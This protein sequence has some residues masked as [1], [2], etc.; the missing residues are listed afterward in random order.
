MDE[1]KN[2]NTES[3]FEKRTGLIVWLKTKRN[4]RRLMNFGL[5]HYV[6]NKMDYAILY[7]DTSQLE[8]T[9]KRLRKENYVKSVEVSHLKELPASYDDVLENM[10]KEIEEK[11]QNDKYDIFSNKI[12]F[13]HHDW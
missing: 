6:S 12:D 4:V 5:L 11:K 13:T 2:I 10:K 9:L 3:D 1:I 8:E 7:V